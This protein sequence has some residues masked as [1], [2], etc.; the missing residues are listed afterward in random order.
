M[1]SGSNQW[2]SLVAVKSDS[3]IV[4]GRFDRQRPHFG[5]AELSVIIGATALLVVVMLVSYWRSRRRKMEFLSNSSPQLFSELSAAHR[6]DRANRRLIKSLAAAGGQ[7]NAAALFVEPGYF[8]TEKLPESEKIS[9][10]A[11][12]QLRHEL[13]E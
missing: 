12:R 9:L 11:F 7:K 3:G 10:D 2:T 5:S 4:W 8:E 6:L 1:T 13:F